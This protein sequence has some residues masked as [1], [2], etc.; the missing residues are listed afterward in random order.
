MLSGK[1]FFRRARRFGVSAIFK[2]PL[3]VTLAHGKKSRGYAPAPRRS[4]YFWKLTPTTVTFT[5]ATSSPLVFS[6]A[7]NTAS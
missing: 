4:F 2:Q 1:E 5:W 6:T 3:R 7:L